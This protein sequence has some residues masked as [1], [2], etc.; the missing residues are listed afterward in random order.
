[1]AEACQEDDLAD[2]A[3]ETLAT[4]PTELDVDAADVTP[5]ALHSFSCSCAGSCA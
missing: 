5:P 4:D 3:L 1:M 2:I